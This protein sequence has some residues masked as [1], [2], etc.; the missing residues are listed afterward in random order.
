CAHYKFLKPCHRCHLAKLFD[1]QG[2]VGNNE[3]TTVTRKG[4]FADRNA[5]DHR[6][7]CLRS[8]RGKSPI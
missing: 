8:Q 7:G 1:N 3:V 2:I 4:D 6:G 5:S